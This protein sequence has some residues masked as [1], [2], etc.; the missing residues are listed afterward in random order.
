MKTLSFAA[1]VMVAL[2]TIATTSARAEDYQARAWAAG[3]AACHGTNGRGGYEVPA[4]AGRS[5]ADLY[6]VMKEFKAD[7]RK[8][9]TI[10]HQHAKGYTDA[11]LERIADFFSRQSR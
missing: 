6:A 8:T 5:K 4:I 2:G 1:G 11:Q 3:C 9:A 7:K 10:M